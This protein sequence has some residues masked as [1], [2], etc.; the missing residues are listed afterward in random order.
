MTSGQD[1]DP[2]TLLP[3][4]AGTWLLDRSAT[5]VELRTKAM[6]GLAKVKGS[7]AA[8]EGGGTVTPDGSVTGFIVM[9]SS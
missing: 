6:W 2:K 7:L 8:T 5:T 3:G 9:D 1:S 4:L